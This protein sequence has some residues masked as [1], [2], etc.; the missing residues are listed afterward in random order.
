MYSHVAGTT[1]YR[2]ADLKTLLAKATPARTGDQLAG[3]AAAS[4]EERVAA[5]M[6]L[7]D[8]PLKAFLNEPVVP[9]EQDEVTRLILDRH[10]A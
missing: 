7:A 2:F 5:Q 10:D 9:Y 3:I 8:V 1:V 4:A 6:A